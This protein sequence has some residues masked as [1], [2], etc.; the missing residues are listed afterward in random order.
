MDG[1][2]NAASPEVWS[3]VSTTEEEEESTGRAHEAEQN[4]VLNNDAD[5]FKHM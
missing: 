4:P 1:V 2:H 3:V 5:V